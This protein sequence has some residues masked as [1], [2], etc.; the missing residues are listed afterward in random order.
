M[1]L[2]LPCSSMTPAF[3]LPCCFVGR[4][5]VGMFVVNVPNPNITPAA[6]SI[7][8]AAGAGHAGSTSAPLA[9]PSAQQGQEQAG[10]VPAGA[11]SDGAGAAPTAPAVEGH[12]DG[13]DDGSSTSSWETADEEDQV[14]VPD[15]A[16][17]AADTHVHSGGTW[18]HL[19]MELPS[20]KVSVVMLVKLVQTQVVMYNCT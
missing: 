7:S 16:A 15:E 8:G 9:P 6:T 18:S 2:A 1:Y 4:Y 11:H 20:K 19:A 10:P 5:K 14:E 12:D 3:V 17:T 13:S